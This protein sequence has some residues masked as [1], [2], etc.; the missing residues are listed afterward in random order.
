M[1]TNAILIVDDNPENL[2]LA[3]AIL[4][5]QGYELYTAAD[6]SE[7]LTILGELSP[8]LIL[9]DIQLPTMDGL[10]LTR[11]LKADLR[12]KDI[13][14]VAVTAYAM[15]GDEQ[16]ARAAGCDG[17][18]SKPIDKRALRALVASYVHNNDAVSG[19]VS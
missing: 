18:L 2:E 15:K 9:L 5:T 7:A 19:R 13:P 1:S 16:R 6:A 14:I 3:L 4:S 11:Q 12:T 17:Y 10:Q 8:A